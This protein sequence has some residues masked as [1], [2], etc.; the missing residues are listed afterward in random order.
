M[1]RA[2]MVSP[3]RTEMWVDGKVVSLRTTAVE[4]NSLVLGNARVELH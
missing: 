4:R 2:A 3:L 1:K